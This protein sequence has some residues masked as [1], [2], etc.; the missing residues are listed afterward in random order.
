VPSSINALRWGMCF[1]VPGFTS[2]KARSSVRMSTTFGGFGSLLSSFVVSSAG[3]R[4]PASAKQPAS[5][6]RKG[7]VVHTLLT[8]MANLPGWFA[9]FGLRESRD[10]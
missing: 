1:S 3:G 2:S 5:S 4:Q 8:R 7:K 10:R 9:T 6:N